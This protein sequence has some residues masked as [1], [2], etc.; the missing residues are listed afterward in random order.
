MRFGD[1]R[2]E[3]ERLL[4]AGDGLVEPV[5]LLEHVTEIDMQSAAVATLQHWTFG[6]CAAQK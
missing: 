4:V 2:I 6:R 3:G 5:K 1:P